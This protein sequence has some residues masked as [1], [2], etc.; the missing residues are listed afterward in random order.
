[1][2]IVV[3]KSEDESLYNDIYEEA[4]RL[5]R[6]SEEIKITVEKVVQKEESKNSEGHCIRCGNKIKM[7]PEHPYCLTDYQKWKKFEDPTYEEKEGVCHVCG[8]PN[9]SSMK[10][11]VCIK[12]YKKKKT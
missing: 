2:G 8:K 7:D 10:K 5:N 1:M 4:L 6:G 12:C 9:S 3:F 11:P